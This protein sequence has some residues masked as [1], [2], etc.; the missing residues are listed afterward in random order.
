MTPDEFRRIALET[1]DDAIERA[2]MNQPDFRAGG[3]I[4]ATID[5]I[6][7]QVMVKLTPE[8]QERVIREHP[9]VFQPAAGQPGR[10][11]GTLIKLA[12]ATEDEVAEALSLAR[13]NLEREARHDSSARRAKARTRPR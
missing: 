8:Q 7:R 1:G 10:Q 4:F 6:H 3:K 12:T 13:E 11:G 5:L 2:H 9:T